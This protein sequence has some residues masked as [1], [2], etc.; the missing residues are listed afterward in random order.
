MTRSNKALS[1][2]LAS[3]E[4][5]KAYY[6]IVLCYMLAFLLYLIHILNIRIL[7]RGGLQLSV[8]RR[9]EDFRVL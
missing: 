1:Y 4:V 3:L 7:F 9:N 6:V 5:I 2:R 8:T